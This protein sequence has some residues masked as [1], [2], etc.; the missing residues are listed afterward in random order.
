MGISLIGLDLPW[1]NP[2]KKSRGKFRYDEDTGEIV[3][4]EELAARQHDKNPYLMPDLD[5]VY[6]GGFQSPIDDTWIT[7]RSQLREHNNRHGVMQTGDVR[8][9]EARERQHKRCRINPEARNA[10]GFSW[11]SP[12]ASR[13]GN[14]TE[15]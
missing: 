7:S 5:V 2:E 10:N 9:A 3:P 4:I 13:N 8:G 11:V 15:I 14:L 6:N 1:L 12:K